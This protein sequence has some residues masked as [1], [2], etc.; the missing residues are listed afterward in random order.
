MI[1]LLKKI[2]QSGNLQ[3]GRYGK[4]KENIIY[5]CRLKKKIDA[6]FITVEK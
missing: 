4:N 6:N 1:K 2:L 5:K 3:R